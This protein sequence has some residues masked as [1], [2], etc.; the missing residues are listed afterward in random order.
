MKKTLFCVALFTLAANS[1]CAQSSGIENN[2][3]VND[4]HK[5]ETNRFWDN[6]F[7][8]VGGGA[9]MYFGDH[10]R[11]MSFGDRLSPALDI[12]VGKWFTPGI[13]VRVMYSGLS[14]KGATQNNIHSNGKPINGKPQ[15]G[16]WLK[17]Q[18]I[19]F[20]NLH[21]D[22][23][24]NLSN[25]FCGY[26][27]TRFWNCSP[28][29][30]IGWMRA[31]EHPSSR[32]VS[33]NLGI[34]NSF[35]VSPAID[36]NLDLRGTLVNDRFDGETGGRREEGLFAAT[37]GLTYKFPKRGWNRSHTVVT[38]DNDA[39]NELRE[40]MNAMSAE[41]ARL[42]QAIAEGNQSAAETIVRKMEV[43]APNL[44][45]F[46]IGKSELSRENRVNLGFL[47]KV[48]KTTDPNAVYTITGYADAGTGTDAINSRLSQERAQAVYDC[49]VKEYG[50]PTSQLRIDHKGG[51]DNMFYDDP[52]LSRAVITR[53]E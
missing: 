8:S 34:L 25:L 28:Y 52:R 47:A 48:I 46:Q 53:N 10:D 37:I 15:Q 32:E 13:G 36:I 6:W 21:G 19:D 12:A 50:I 3:N 49:L 1:I 4:K 26:S 9:Q 20:F 2:E 18:E 44:V 42:Q 16:Y 23:L 39:L 45:T 29:V 41:N 43:A 27:E 35:R 5:V 38:Y 24:F 30:G 14:L 11:Q 51:V 40:K 22:V 17:E 33:A 7:I 31:W